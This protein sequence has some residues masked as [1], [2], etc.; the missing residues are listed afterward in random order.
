MA[1]DNFTDCAG[2]LDASALVRV[3]TRTTTPPNG[4]GLATRLLRSLTNTP[5]VYAQHYNGVDFDPLGANIGAE[6]IGCIKRGISGGTTGFAPFI[7]TLL[8]GN[9]VANEAYVLGLADSEPSHLV[10]RKA[11]LSAGLPD[12]AA[13]TQGILRRSTI[14]FARDTWVQVKV[15]AKVNSPGGIPSDRVV[16]VEYNNLA[17]NPVDAPVWLPVPGMADFIDDAAGFASGSP[18]FTEGRM[19]Y[20]MYTEADARNAFFDYFSIIGDF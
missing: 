9:N 20:G 17:V 5:G 13:G 1:E 12:L 4:G 2:V 10:L 18:G 3:A 6:M 8:Q 11:A 16:Y 19:G 7:F 15:G 14:T